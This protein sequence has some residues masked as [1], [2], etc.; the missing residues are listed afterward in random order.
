MKCLG[1][2]LEKIAYAVGITGLIG[3]LIISTP[4]I[5]RYSSEQI[6]EKSVFEEYH[7]KRYVQCA[8][9]TIQ[10]QD[11]LA[12][13][14]Q[15]S[16]WAFIASSGINENRKF[17][18]LMNNEE[19]CYELP[20]S[21]ATRND[22][23]QAF[24]NAVKNPKVGYYFNG[25]TLMVEN[26]IYDI[27]AYCWEN[28]DIYGLQD[29]YYQFEKTDD[30]VKVRWW[31]ST[32]L[33]ELKNPSGMQ[34]GRFSLDNIRLRN[35][36]INLEGWCYFNGVNCD[37]QKVY[38]EFINDKGE[39]AQY[40]AKQVLRSDVSTYFDEPIYEESG[41][42]ASVPAEKFDNGTYT[43]KILL[44]YDGVIQ[45]SP[46]YRMIKNSNNILLEKD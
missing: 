20:V 39:V 25:S 14:F 45:E 19:N 17:T 24:P 8:V 21:T 11:N 1:R 36:A 33:E 16:G 31:P 7:G 42:F 27:Y 29:I 30:S 9:D 5:S 2:I 32:E 3:W 35:E 13:N 22:V 37:N 41:F 26:G 28:D 34:L 40:T 23:V 43:I 15:I 6:I 18:I 38:V 4:V 10:M 46:S 12:K 44:E